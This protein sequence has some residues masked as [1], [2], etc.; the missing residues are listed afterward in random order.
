MP[1]GTYGS[2]GQ[3]LKNLNSPY[4][5]IQASNVNDL[6]RVGFESFRLLEMDRVISGFSVFGVKRKKDFR[7]RFRSSCFSLDNFVFYYHCDSFGAKCP[8][9]VGDGRG[10]SPIVTFD[11]DRNLQRGMQGERGE[12]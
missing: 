2:G 7:F 4:L 6:S 8:R 9:A 3:C 1:S 5:R 10:V 11:T 12:R